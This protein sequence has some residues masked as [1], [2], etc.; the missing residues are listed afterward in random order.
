MKVVV[1]TDTEAIYG[2]RILSDAAE[3][4]EFKISRIYLREPVDGAGIVTRIR[5]VA[6]KSGMEYTSARIIGAVRLRYHNWLH[7]KRYSGDLG[8]RPCLSFNELSDRH[9]LELRR[10]VDLN[11]SEV[12]A[13]LKED[14]TDLIVSV[15]CG[16]IISPTTL[17]ASRLGGINVHPSLLPKLAGKNPVYW[18]LAEGEKD[19]GL[20]IHQMTQNVDGGPIVG[21]LRIPI[22]ESD[23]HH[24][25]YRR[26]VER[27]SPFLASSIRKISEGGKLEGKA[28]SAAQL[29]R[30]GS[31]TPESFGAFRRQG[32]RFF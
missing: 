16:Q 27:G 1:F 9:D 4:K 32:R 13:E 30:R 17:S 21:Q 20:T 29:D 18:A 22:M 19:T 23:S 3:A 31:P 2:P 14:N 11:T 10:V 8:M 15:F 7:R 12:T 24:D 26:I 6:E 5:M 25:L 28:I